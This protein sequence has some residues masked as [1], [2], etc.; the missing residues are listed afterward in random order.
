[1]EGD[2]VEGSVD[3]V[4]REEEVVHAL[5]EMKTEKISGHSE[6]SLE[7]IA[8]DGEVGIQVIVE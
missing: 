5:G 2:T 6:V 3:C 1:M 4:G 7:M 8:T